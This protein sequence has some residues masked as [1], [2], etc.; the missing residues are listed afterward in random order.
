MI[1]FK[2]TQD[3]INNFS[4]NVPVGTVL[5][6]NGYYSTADA[7]GAKWVKTTTAVGTP[8]Q[9]PMQLAD[10][11]LTDAAGYEWELSGKSYIRASQLGAINGADNT[12]A[13]QACLN[14]VS[15]KGEVVDDT[16]STLLSAVLECAG[17]SVEITL[18]DITQTAEASVLN[19]NGGVEFIRSIT[20]I[21]LDNAVR[22]VTCDVTDLNVGDFVKIISDDRLVGTRPA[23]GVVSGR[24]GQFATVRS[25]DTE[26]GT[27]RTQERF[28]F[29]YA[30]NPR[31]VKLSGHSINLTIKKAKFHDSVVGLNTAVRVYNA[32]N[33]EFDLRFGR[34][35][36]IGLN[37][38]GCYRPWVK[39]VYISFNPLSSPTFGH[40]ISDWSCYGIRVDGI[41]SSS[42]RHLFTTNNQPLAVGSTDVHYYGPSYGGVVN[43]M[44]G[45]GL[46]DAFIDT[47]HGCEDFTFIGGNYTGHS[48][49]CSVRGRRITWHG[50]QVNGAAAG[51]IAFSES[52]M[53]EVDFSEDIV[54]I[55][56]ILR[57]IKGS[58]F[59]VQRTKR[60][61]IINPTI[62]AESGFSEPYKIF[63]INNSQVD[64]YGGTL[65][66]AG[67]DVDFQAIFL[68]FFSSDVT[69]HGRCEITIDNHTGISPR[70][71][72]SGGV[73]SNSFVADDLVIKNIGPDIGLI[74][75]SNTA[76]IND[77]D[78]D[79]APLYV[80]MKMRW[81]NITQFRR[82][83]SGSLLDP[84]S[85]MDCDGPD[86]TTG[87]RDSIAT[88]VA[89]Q[90]IG[91]NL[92]IGC[93]SYLFTIQ[94]AGDLSAG[95]LYRP[96]IDGSRL[97][98]RSNTPNDV[99]IPEGVGL[100]GVAVLHK[101]GLSK[102]F[103]ASKQSASYIY[104]KRYDTWYEV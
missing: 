67:N 103:T 100:N 62:V 83:V 68:L 4:G 23:E 74:T 44:Q 30:T 9:S 31:L 96:T 84:A 63:E 51:P 38:Y 18:N 95:G 90:I 89:D 55:N 10:G 24:Q 99:T 61:K 32:V 70:I 25:I 39:R 8:N 35:P 41:G 80:R 91:D 73:G 21:D 36:F 53:S 87:A 71:V 102:V 79:L 78:P 65:S 85:S 16:E 59:R 5:K 98:L 48:P 3:F 45:D 15:D 93:S 77:V 27:F 12:L 28:R 81:E 49:S 50:L 40:G 72:G 101:D 104:S 47:H 57:N 86:M 76:T 58:P 33:S 19:Y 11:L 2:T 75:A 17:K 34:L 26:A 52:D 22:T 6:T 94:A 54:F 88:I 60:C 20:A 29:D 42:C 37:L 13:L 66:C 46:Q 69:V 92:F 14:A 97:V 7:G 43:C 82:I 56:P 1:N 64:I